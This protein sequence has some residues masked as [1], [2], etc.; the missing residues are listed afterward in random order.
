MIGNKIVLNVEG[1]WTIKLEQV[2]LE[3]MSFKIEREKV[4]MLECKERLLGSRLAE[5]T[6]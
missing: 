6:K 3:S 5:A 4:H 2:K 1:K